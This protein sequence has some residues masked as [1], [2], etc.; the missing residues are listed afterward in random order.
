MGEFWD[1]LKEGIDLFKQI[2]NEAREL[3]TDGIPK[4]ILGI[5]PDYQTSYERVESAEG[6]IESA[7]ERYESSL[8]HLKRAIRKA[9]KESS[10]FY[11]EKLITQNS[12]IKDSLTR[13]SVIMP[14]H[15]EQLLHTQQQFSYLKAKS[16]RKL[17]S[18]VN[19]Y[20]LKIASM[21]ECEVNS[22]PPP[23]KLDNNSIQF[24][25]SDFTSGINTISLPIGNFLIG[26]EQKMRVEKSKQ[27]L[28]QARQFD[29]QVD[30]QIENIRLYRMEINTI[31]Q[32]I[33]EG[34]KLIKGLSE[35]LTNQMEIVNTIKPRRFLWFNLKATKEEFKTAMVAYALITG[36]DN[37]CDCQIASQNGKLDLE[38]TQL[39]DNLNASF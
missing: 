17:S 25:L 9:Q 13:L 35:L 16:I 26:Y 8:S 1:I 2:R 7:K 23:I 24:G 22:H 4:M 10:L 31:L 11:E 19:E 39:L 18:S 28:E 6:I 14:T 37:L 27:Y 32:K 29:L 36:I 3:V 20:E 33:K 15:S 38:Y 30:I 5:E 12:L 34:R 21:R